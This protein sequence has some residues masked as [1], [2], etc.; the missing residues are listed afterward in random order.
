MMQR[1]RVQQSFEADFADL[2]LSLLLKKQKTRSHRWQE[3]EEG[4]ASRNQ[5]TDGD[6]GVRVLRG[7]RVTQCLVREPR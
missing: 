4:Q 3:R 6:V 5:V 7:H 2:G 1:H